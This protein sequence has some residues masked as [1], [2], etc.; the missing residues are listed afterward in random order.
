MSSIFS[1]SASAQP[2][3]SAAALA[4]AVARAQAEVD[5]LS[6]GL[7]DL[8]ESVNRALVDLRDAQAIAEQ[9]RR[10]AAEAEERLRAAEADV[11]A[12]KAALASVTRSQYRGASESGVLGALAGDG[13]QKDVLERA[14]FL[15]QRTDEKR[16]ALAAVERARTEAAN[17]AAVAREASELADA[18][19]SEAV[20]A[21]QSARELLE[22]SAASLEVQTAELQ[23]AEA[24]L[25]AAQ[26]ELEEARP[27]S[28][29]A[30]ESAYAAPAEPVRADAY[31]A[32]VIEDVQRRVEEL[33]PEASAPSAD[34]VAQA[35]ASA[36]SARGGATDAAEI[37]E[38][39]I[40]DAA[41]VAAAAALV[42]DSQVPHA[43]FADPY[44]GGAGG[45]SLSSVGSLSSLGSLSSSLDLGAVTDSGAAEII[46]AF[47]GGLQSGM[48]LSDSL[49]STNTTGDVRLADAINVASAIADVAGV[50]PEVSTPETVTKKVQ[51]T[52]TAPN[53][54]SVETVISR[55][56]SMVGTPYVWGGGDANGPTTGVNGGSLNGFDCSGLVLYAFSGAGVSLPHYTG[57]QYQRGT[58]IDP[59]QAQRGDL[60]FWGPGGSQHV[61]IYLGD[62]MM[63]EAPRAGQNV[64]VVPVRW[65]GMSE[66][67]VRLL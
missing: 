35:L 30:T 8:Q 18:T 15:R 17:E 12:A 46:T 62:G 26:Q 1:P 16:E 33:A 13:K 66:H 28:T 23:A 63:I 60:L 52:V 5:N 32:A 49:N 39:A 20:K 53:S 11:D 29:V 22:T 24:S 4:A 27:G 61:A 34:V 51:S 55:A 7:G 57:Y 41:Q 10:G 47:A 64:S 21:E 9:A 19:A 59:S 44:A 42:G 56:M 40:E 14:N 38:G 36:H 31:D 50:L 48:G 37:S 65:S 58:K 43:T 67:A 45:S 6:L 25:G 54:G 2:E 3:Q